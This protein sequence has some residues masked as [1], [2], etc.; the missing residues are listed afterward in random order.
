MKKSDI[1]F[2][3]IMGLGMSLIM[4]LVITFINTGVDSDYLKKVLKFGKKK[5]TTTMDDVFEKK[6]NYSKYFKNGC[7][8]RG[9]QD[10]IW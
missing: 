10:I 7:S 4:T 1:V 2:T 5:F 9:G 6:K 8:W 3:A